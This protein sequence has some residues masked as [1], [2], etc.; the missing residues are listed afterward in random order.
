MLWAGLRARR[1]LV[2]WI[3]SWVGL[4]HISVEIDWQTDINWF[5]M[6][7]WSSGTSC[8][9]E[10][11]RR[12]DPSEESPII[13]SPPDPSS[14]RTLSGPPKRRRTSESSD[15][16]YWLSSSHSGGSHIDR[17]PEKNYRFIDYSPGMHYPTVVITI[18]WCFLICVCDIG[19]FRRL[20]AIF[21]TIFWVL[22]ALFSFCGMMVLFL[23]SYFG[24]GFWY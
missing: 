11:L 14:S 7:N 10:R 22:L 18:F 23:C 8:C 17:F 16:S 19:I 3:S 5:Q 4:R 1:K 6:P 21:I 20:I 15:S 24:L 2:G 9:M 13:P 12:S